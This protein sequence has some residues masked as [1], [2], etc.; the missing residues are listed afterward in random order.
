MKIKLL[1]FKSVRSTNDVAFKL[2]KEKKLLPT[3]I[4][5]EK[6]THGRGTMGKKWVSKKENLFFS[7]YFELNQKKINFKHY[8]ILNAYLLKAIIS[9]EISKKI[10][11]KWPN[12]LLFKNKK[13]CGIL[14]E[15]VNY[16]DKKI[17]IV[18]IGLNTN[19]DPQNKGFSSTCLKDI[20]NKN[21]DNNKL[22][23]KIKITYEKFLI[24]A[25]NFSYLELKSLYK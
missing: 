4:S 6:Q 11:I 9:K 8:A 10:R 19:I 2:I 25:Q 20:T 14:Q 7:I 21:I 13:I 23:N 17:L 12:D 5:A 15:V 3:I 18:G 16:K 24:K 1:K 22:L